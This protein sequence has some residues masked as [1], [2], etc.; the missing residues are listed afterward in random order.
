LLRE[1]IESEIRERGPI[2]LD[3]YMELCL[4]HSKFG[5]YMQR[6]P[7]GKK[8]D[9]TTAPE[10]SQMFGELV[11]LWLAQRWLDMGT[12]TPFALVELGPGRGTL[13]ADILRAAKGVPEFLAAA[14]IILVETSPRLRE[15]QRETL[16]NLEIKHID[17][18]NALPDLPIICLANEFF[19]ALPIRQFVRNDFGWQ[20]RMLGAGLKPV[21]SETTEM[22]KLDSRFERVPTGTIVE[23]CAPSSHIINVITK[24]IETRG[25][26]A[27]IIDYGAFDGTG[28]T[29]QAVQNHQKVDPFSAPGRADLTAHVRFC[30]LV[31][32]TLEHAFTEQGK[33]LLELGIDAR[34]KVLERHG[35]KNATE[36]QERLTAVNEMGSLFKVLAI[37]SLP[38]D[39]SCGFLT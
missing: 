13:M 9:F 30:D 39:Q 33:F 26:T 28:D 31:D 16:K 10:I 14:Q 19:D 24:Y 5:Y 4:S 18:V 38:V 25:G 20:E 15:A 22:P 27:L 29:F 8:G 17:S 36:A 35:A 6:Q 2:G 3:R 1:I 11:G 37:S 21:L 23:T 7:F 34:R 12:P 32:D